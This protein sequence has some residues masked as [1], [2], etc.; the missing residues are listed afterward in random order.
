MNQYIVGH[1]GAMGLAPENTLKAFKIGCGSNVEVVECD[2]HLSK[3]KKLIVIHDNTLDR[4]TNG[5]GW[6]RD[7][8]LEELKKLD[9]GDGETI[10]TLDEVIN[11]VM[12]YNKKLII[13]IKGESWE[14]VKETTAHLIEYLK[15]NKYSDKFIIH[16]F[17]HA[18]VKLIKEK[19]PQIKTSVIMMLG[20]PPQ[21]M[22]ALIESA[23]ADG[24][25]IAYDY[26]S[27][28]LVRLA[29]EKN[30]FLD[31]WVLDYETT[32][33]R[34]KEIGVNGLITNHPGKFSL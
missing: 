21:K 10:P 27:P 20:L 12:D 3:D 8:T 22:I 17:W 5:E 18:A 14:V 30:L 2:I 26:I 1:R 4:T 6:V 28:E 33:N 25:A 13:E 16:S 15:G 24:A 32:F 34:L 31:A 19:Y 23:N 9:A 11:L 7:F 29:K